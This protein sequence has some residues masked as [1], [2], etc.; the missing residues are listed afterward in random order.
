VG[1]QAYIWFGIAGGSMALALS[2]L[3]TRFVRRDPQAVRSGGSF[4]LFAVFMLI[5]A[6]GALV[7][8]FVSVRAGR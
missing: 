8:A 6:V 1:P 2:L 4:T 3:Y 7:A 5:F